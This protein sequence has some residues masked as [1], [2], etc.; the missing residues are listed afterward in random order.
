MSMLYS[1][2]PSRIL[3]RL[4]L[5][6]CQAIR[7]ALREEGR[8]RVGVV[9]GAELVGVVVQDVGR[10]VVG[11]ALVLVGGA[12]VVLWAIVLEVTGGCLVDVGAAVVERGSREVSG[13]TLV[14]GQ[15][16]VVGA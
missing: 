1:Q 15:P 4:A 13:S 2:G 12:K 11:F 3:V 10:E 7:V 9:V 8:A 16:V 14:V 6:M 5:H